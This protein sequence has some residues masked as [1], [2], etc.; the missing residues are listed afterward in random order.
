MNNLIRNN[1]GALL[2]KKDYR[3]RI[4]LA[5]MSA[6]P[7]VTQANLLTDFSMFGVW[8]QMKT[9]SCVAQSIAKLMQLYWYLKTGK[10]VPFNPQ[11]LYIVSA[12]PGTSP[13]DGRDPRTV[14]K[15]ASS[16]GCCT[17]AT[18]P[19]NNNVPNAT[20]FNPA[21]I[22]QAMRDEAMQYAGISFVPVNVDENSIRNAIQNYGGV[23]ALFEVGNT[24]WTANDGTVTWDAKLIDPIRATNNLTSGH[25][26]TLIGDFN[27]DVLHGLNSWGT[28]WDL[29]G[30]FNFILNEWQ[31]YI[32]E[33]WAITSPNPTALALIQ[34]LPTDSEFKH[35]FQA[36][37]KYGMSNPEVRALQVAL[38]IDGD[39]VY[40]EVTGNYG[41]NTSLAV[42][43]FQTKYAVASPAVINSLKG[44]ASQVG[45]LTRAKLNQLFNY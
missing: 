8:D 34:S 35:N 23:S 3:D 29:G 28:D 18:L 37:L 40:P 39:F 44:T 17:T 31:P 12:P 20:Y 2:S 10:V 6:N 36:T 9:P 33:L 30:H 7:V 19:L 22:T 11:F 1:T 15:A 41:N 32:P 4:F 43:A 26:V 16:I 24:F 27:S 45:P 42:T 5:A 25:E 14:L 38:A 13:E 21:I